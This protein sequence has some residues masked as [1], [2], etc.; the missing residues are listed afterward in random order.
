MISN[1]LLP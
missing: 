1:H